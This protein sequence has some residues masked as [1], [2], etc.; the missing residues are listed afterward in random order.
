MQGCVRDAPIKCKDAAL[1]CSQS[2]KLLIVLKTS[3]LAQP[4]LPAT[5][6]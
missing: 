4:V 2:P 3:R 6:P 5:Q 1:D